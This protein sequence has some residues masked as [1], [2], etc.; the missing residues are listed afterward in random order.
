ME[1]AGGGQAEGEMLRLKRDAKAEENR[2]RERA[3]TPQAS[4]LWWIRSH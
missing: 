1:Q 2:E 3:I 4:E